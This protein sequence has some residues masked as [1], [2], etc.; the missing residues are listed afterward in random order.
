VVFLE[1]CNHLPDWQFPI[2]D[3]RSH[4]NAASRILEYSGNWATKGWN[5][6]SQTPSMLTACAASSLSRHIGSEDRHDV[7]LPVP[8]P[9]LPGSCPDS[10]SPP[11]RRMALM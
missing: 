4:S 3:F 8:C 10:A 5:F 9:T 7:P 11:S 1:F 2:V 6:D